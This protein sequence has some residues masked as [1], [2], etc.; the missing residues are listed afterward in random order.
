MINGLART[1]EKRGHNVHVLVLQH[2]YETVA[3]MYR[4]TNIKVLVTPSKNLVD[5]INSCKGYILPLATYKDHAIWS[6]LTFSGEIGTWAYAPYLQ[7][8]VNPDYMRRHFKVFRDPEREKTLFNSLDIK[9]GEYIFEHKDPSNKDFEIV[10]D[11]KIINPDVT[12]QNY[13]TFDWLLVI[14]NAKEVHCANSGPWPWIVELMRIGGPEKNVFHIRAAHQEYQDK[15]V[16]NTFSDDIW[17]F[18]D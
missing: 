13:N 10:S 7:A 15:C 3:F 2:Q 14:E 12:S 18:K 16:K 6:T 9:P 1:L 8:G 11:L 5:I 4:D 17:T